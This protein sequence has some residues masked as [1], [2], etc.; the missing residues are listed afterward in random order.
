MDVEEGN[1]R[2]KVLH[3]AG[4]VLNRGELEQ[5]WLDNYEI[6]VQV[7]PESNTKS[8]GLC[9]TSL[10]L[11]YRRMMLSCA[12]SPSVALFDR[13]QSCESFKYMPSSTS[14]SHDP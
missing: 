10:E 9:W 11:G 3:L 5:F 4:S 13:D 8:L 2:T 14:S 7:Y 1:V 6:N 12:R